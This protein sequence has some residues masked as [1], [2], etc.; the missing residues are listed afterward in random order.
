VIDELTSTGWL[1]KG[2]TDILPH[3]YVL[4]FQTRPPAPPSFPPRVPPT[5]RAPR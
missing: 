5:P 3:Q 4:V 1:L 2:E